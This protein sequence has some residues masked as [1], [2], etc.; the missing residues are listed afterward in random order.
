MKHITLPEMLTEDQIESAL[1]LYK[2]F[3]GTGRFATECAKQVI[4]PNLAEIARK[5]GQEMDAKYVA[6]AC[7]YVFNSTSQ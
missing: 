7:E 6:Y 1:A 4:E 2:K 3:K 5:C